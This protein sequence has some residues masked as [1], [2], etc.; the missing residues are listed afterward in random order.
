MIDRA[1][2]ATYRTEWQTALATDPDGLAVISWNE[3]SENSHIEPS[4]AYGSRYLEVTAGLVRSTLG[5]PAATDP[6]SATLAPSKPEPTGS[7]LPAITTL[8]SAIPR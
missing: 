4:V 1:D 7:W 3:F 2:G 5:R 8:F 6:A